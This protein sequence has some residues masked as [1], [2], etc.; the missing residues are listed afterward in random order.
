MNKIVIYFLL[1]FLSFYAGCEQQKKSGITEKKA[2]LKSKPYNLSPIPYDGNSFPSFLVGRW[3]AADQ[4]HF[5][6]GFQFDKNGRITALRNFLNMYM[7][8]KEGGAFE[9]GVD[10]NVESACTLGSTDVNYDPN[11]RILS[12]KVVTDYF[13][14]HIYEDILEGSSIDTITGSVSADGNFWNAQWT[15]VSRM[16]S[17]PPYDFNN[18]SVYDVNFYKAED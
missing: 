14:M 15:N 11:G 4:N 10:P 6:W 13:M 12:V 1:S 5:K 2:E 18:P 17:G 8:V 7:T 3:K 9:T 16:L